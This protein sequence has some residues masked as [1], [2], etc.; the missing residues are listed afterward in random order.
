MG[1]RNEIKLR[2]GIVMSSIN[3]RCSLCFRKENSENLVSK[4]SLQ[5]CPKCYKKYEESPHNQRVMLLN[6]IKLYRKLVERYENCGGVKID[7]HFE[8]IS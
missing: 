5:L 1:R 8:G 2:G 6:S 4:D 3:E 7:T